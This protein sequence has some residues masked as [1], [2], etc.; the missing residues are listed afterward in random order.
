MLLEDISTTRPSKAVRRTLRGLAAKNFLG[1]DFSNPQPET[2]DRAFAW[3]SMSPV[4]GR[5]IDWEFFSF[6]KEVQKR[7]F[8]KSPAGTFDP[9]MILK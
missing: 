2:T 7:E 9:V 3:P 6:M 8:I 5:K 1:G 4:I